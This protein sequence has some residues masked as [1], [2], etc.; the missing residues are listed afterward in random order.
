MKSVGN[1]YRRQHA[2][3]FLILVEAL[4]PLLRYLPLYQFNR[5]CIGKALEVD[6]EVGAV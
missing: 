6:P 1:S 4:L 2:A 3:S 5:M